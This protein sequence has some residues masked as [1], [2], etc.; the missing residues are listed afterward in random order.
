MKT[1]VLYVVYRTSMVSDKEQVEEIIDFSQ[2]REV[3][4]KICDMNKEKGITSKVEKE[5]A[6][7]DGNSEL[8][9]V[10]NEKSLNLKD[11][12]KL[13]DFKDDVIRGMGG[14]EKRVLLEA[15]ALSI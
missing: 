5:L 11:A 12:K 4:D 10:K 1:Q 13:K 8:Y 9:I 3:A 6:C 7:S 15:G 2:D 14:F